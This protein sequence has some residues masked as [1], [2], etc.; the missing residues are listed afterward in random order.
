[1]GERENRVEKGGLTESRFFRPFDRI[2]KVSIE[3]KS[4]LARGK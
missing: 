3:E 4:H 2:Q 1:M